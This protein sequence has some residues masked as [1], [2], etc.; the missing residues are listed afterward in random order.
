MAVLYANNAS[1]KLSASITNTAT[2]FSVTT[3][4]GALFPAIT[5]ADYF[6]ATLVDTAGNLEIVK[7]TARATDTLTVVRGQDGTT[8]RAFSAND[9]VEL[10]ITKSM[11]DDVKAELVAQSGKPTSSTTAP[12]T[13][14]ANQLW[15]DTTNGLLK[16][17]YNDGN[18]SQWV[19]AFPYATTS[20]SSAGG[21]FNNAYVLTGTT[22]DGAETEIFVDGVA[23]NRVPV[24]LNKTVSFVIEIT[25]RRTDGA[26]MESVIIS[27]RCAAVNNAGTTA[28]LGN[29]AETIVFRSD[30][31]FNADARSSSTTDTLNIYVQGATGKTLSW[32]AVVQT[33]EV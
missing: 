26:T 8:A 4:Q 17:Y 12:S 7:V 5:G 25:G 23:N 10:R 32:R 27:Q 1:S 11:L 21:V 2:S 22:T 9:T 24:T 19:D 18:T 29:I 33:V 16:I 28:D 6:Y 20:V 31:A 13:P 15:W 14:S 3:G 30:V